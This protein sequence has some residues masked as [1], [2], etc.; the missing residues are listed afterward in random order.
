MSISTWGDCQQI[1]IESSGD[2]RISTKKASVLIKKRGTYPPYR[3]RS[4]VSSCTRSVHLPIHDSWF[5]F[6]NVLFVGK[7]GLRCSYCLP[8][9]RFVSSQRAKHGAAIPMLCPCMLLNFRLLDQRLMLAYTIN[10]FFGIFPEVTDSFQSL[11]CPLQIPLR[12]RPYPYPASSSR[13]SLPGP[14]WP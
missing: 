12:C 2:H 3:H 1:G 6:L 7:H 4:H 13:P 5:M 11:P 10:R 9:F 8:T 14:I